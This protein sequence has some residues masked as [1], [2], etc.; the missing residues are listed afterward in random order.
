MKRKYTLS[1]LLLIFSVISSFFIVH[2]PLIVETQYSQRQRSFTNSYSIKNLFEPFWYLY[3][4][5]NPTSPY[6]YQ[7]VKNPELIFGP[8]IDFSVDGWFG[9]VDYRLDPLHHNSTG[10]EWF[11]LLAK[12]IN[13]SSIIGCFADY[14]KIQSNT[15]GSLSYSKLFTSEDIDLTQMLWVWP[16]NTDIQF[17]IEE[18]TRLNS[19]IHQPTGSYLTTYWNDS[20]SSL[21]IEQKFQQGE[22]ISYITRIVDTQWSGTVWLQIRGPLFFENNETVFTLCE[23][24]AFNYSISPYN[25][26]DSTIISYENPT[27]SPNNSSNTIQDTNEDFFKSLSTSII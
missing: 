22:N 20:D 19:T 7:L 3:S 9:D 6:A 18:G 2:E 23:Q 12:E 1:N 11:F 15:T 21:V 25:P 8:G 13:D 14:K 27:D 10:V 4:S 26:F 5:T 16:N 17:W 24:H